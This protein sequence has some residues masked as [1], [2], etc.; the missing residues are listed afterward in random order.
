MKDLTA[1]LLDLAAR[2]DGPPSQRHLHSHRCGDLAREAAK[3]IER[4][5]KIIFDATM[6][7][8]DDDWCGVMGRLPAVSPCPRCD[9]TGSY[10][11]LMGRS[12][13]CAVCNGL[14][15]IGPNGEPARLPQA[16]VD[17]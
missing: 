11:R 17:R 8:P 6:T 5:R 14:G 9:G 2:L 16:T 3:E 12:V 15:G 1:R 13:P 4:L 10:Q 7:G